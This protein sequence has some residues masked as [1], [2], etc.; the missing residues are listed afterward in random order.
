M[1]LPHA[2]LAFGRERLAGIGT[3]LSQSINESAGEGITMQQILTQGAFNN[4]MAVH[5]AIGG[6][7]NLLLHLPAIAYHAGV[8]RPTVEQW[9][10]FNRAIP[11][12]V[13]VLPNGPQNFRTVQVFLA[14]GVPEIM[15]H[16]RK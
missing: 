15:L 14:G 4:A 7:T 9:I 10:H 1:T 6:S 11:R 12:I 2:A 3:L 13:D 16:L 8:N 5:A